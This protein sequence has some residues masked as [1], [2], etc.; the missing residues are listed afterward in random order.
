MW[1]SHSLEMVQGCWARYSGLSLGR[2]ALLE[3]AQRSELETPT[4][5]RD[6][7]PR[8]EHDNGRSKG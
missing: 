7:V 4:L 2:A 3:L 5:L 8:D 6:D 1:S